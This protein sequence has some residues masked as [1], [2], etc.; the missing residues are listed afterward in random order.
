MKKMSEMRKR[1]ARLHLHYI[2]LRSEP[3]GLMAR[4]WGTKPARPGLWARA[5]G[6]TIATTVAVS[7]KAVGTGENFGEAYRPSYT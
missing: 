3:H 2:C 7:E 6:P 5:C 4:A 1:A